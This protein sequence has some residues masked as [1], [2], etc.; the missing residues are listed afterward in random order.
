MKISIITI[1][2]NNKEGLI[3][4]V[5]SVINQSYK[6]IE[7]IIID[8]ASTDGSAEYIKENVSHFSYWI[9]EQDKGIYNAMNKGIDRTTGEYLLF[10]NS[11][12]YLAENDVIEKFIGFKPVEDIVYGDVFIVDID[13]C[14]ERSNYPVK[15]KLKDFFNASIPHPATFIK[16]YLFDKYGLYNENNK[17]VSDWE[18][19]FKI[20]QLGECDFRKIELVPTVFNKDGIS[21]SIEGK[22][23]HR[24]ER[25]KVLEKLLPTELIELLTEN[26]KLQND[27]NGL[28]SS[29]SVKLALKVSFLLNSIKSMKR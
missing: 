8:G 28:L 15:V 29:G 6:N 16:S 23:L 10:L 27:Y 18:F 12:D 3:K 25:K 5:N 21:S 26:Q 17:I 7:Y 24:K 22:E 11:G 1:N 14:R 20:Y 2:Y 9:S 19:F 4:T 13:S